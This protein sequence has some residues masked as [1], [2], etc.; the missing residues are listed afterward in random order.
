MRYKAFI[1]YSHTDKDVAAKLEGAL[2]GF[3]KAWYQP[4][5]RRIFRDDS[6]IQLGPL[7]EG[8]AG[9]LQESEFFLLLASPAAAKS[10]WVAREVD[11]WLQR[12]G[13]TNLLIVLT[14]G[15]LA[16]N[17]ARSTH[18]PER[19]TAL[20]SPLIDAF[21]R[22]PLYADLSWTGEPGDLTLANPDFKKTIAQL[23]A[24]L[25]DRSTEDMIGAEIEQHNKTRRIRNAAVITLSVLLA[26]AIVF[27]GL[28][29]WQTRV[30][31]RQRNEAER[32]RDRALA[33]Q[34]AAG[35][36][37]ALERRNWSLGGLLALESIR[38]DWTPTGFEAWQGAMEL[39]PP[40]S[41][42]LASPEPVTD[43]HF[44][45]DST[46]LFGKSGNSL[47]R[48]EISTSPAVILRRP[49]H[50]PPSPRHQPTWAFDS[51]GRHLVTTD[52]ER[53]LVWD[54]RT[55]ESS[56]QGMPDKNFFAVAISPDGQWIA[57]LCR[58][59]P[60]LLIWKTGSAGAP[61]IV[62][63][64]DNGEAIMSYAFSP[65]SRWFAAGLRTSI[66]IWEL[67]S[68]E[69]QS[70]Q[71]PPWDRAWGPLAFSPDRRWL[72]NWQGGVWRTADWR[73]VKRINPGTY[74]IPLVF[75]TRKWLAIPVG[76]R[77][78]VLAVG[79]WD[80][81]PALPD[82][83]GDHP[84]FSPDDRWL[85]TQSRRG[86]LIGDLSGKLAPRWI[87][88]TDVTNVAFSP[89][90]RW[91]ATGSSDGTVHIWQTDTLREESKLSLD[92]KVRA[93]AFSPGSK[94]LATGSSTA[95]RLWDV[96]SRSVEIKPRMT[97]A[98][99]GSGNSLSAQRHGNN[100]T[101]VRADG[102]QKLFEVAHA[103]QFGNAVFSPDGQWVAVLLTRGDKTAAGARLWNLQTL[104]ME[105]IPGAPVAF[106]PD[107]RK[108]LTDLQEEDSL[109]LTLLTLDASSPPVTWT[110]HKQR[111]WNSLT[112]PAA[113][114][115]ADGSTLAIGTGT[116]TR[117]RR[118]KPLDGRLRVWHV[119]DL[120][121][122]QE[123]AFEAPVTAVDFSP[124]GARIALII[125]TG[126][127]DNRGDLLIRDLV[128][129]R[130][131]NG[132]EI[133]GQP[134][135]SAN[136]RRLVALGQQSPARL[137]AW[138]LPDGNGPADGLQRSDFGVAG[139]PSAWCLSADGELV[140][141][142]THD[143][144]IR[145]R[146]VANG[147]E[148]WR[149][150]HGGVI[151]EL[152]FSQSGKELKSFSRD[153]HFQVWQTRS[154]L[155]VD[156]S[157]GAKWSKQRLKALER[158]LARQPLESPAWN[159]ITD[160]YRVTDVAFSPDKRW[161]A[162]TGED[163]VVMIWT[164]PGG[165][166]AARLPH[167]QTPQRLRFDNNGRWLAVKSTND[168]CIWSVGLWEL[169]SCKSHA[170]SVA[171][172]VFSPSGSYVATLSH[173]SLRLW[174]PDQPGQIPTLQHS[175]KVRAVAFS[176][177]ERLVATASDT[178]E[179]GVWEIPSGEAILTTTLDDPAA[180]AALSPDNEWLAV[181]ADGDI[182]VLEVT[183]G[184]EVARFVV[185]DF[186]DAGFTSEG[187][188]LVGSTDSE[189]Y[190][191]PWSAA[192][193]VAHTCQ[194]LPRNLSYE[195]WN[196]YMSGQP[197]QKTCPGLPLHPS[198]QAEADQR[199]EQGDFAG[200]V[201][202]LSLIHRLDKGKIDQGGD[203]ERRAAP[204]LLVSG[205]QLARRG[206]IKEALEA[207]TEAREF[208]P[209]IKIAPKAW[210][211]LCWYGSLWGQP[212]LVLRHCEQAV[213]LGD[214]NVRLRDSR[215]LARALT[216]DY[217]G[218][219]D[220]FQSYINN[221]SSLEEQKEKRR[222]WIETLEAGKNPFTPEVLEILRSEQT[223]P[224]SFL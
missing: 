16:W 96:V 21:S 151:T 37:E 8:V 146:E 24:T 129:D 171:G 200:A 125:A 206:R 217:K 214:Q 111:G 139:R 173:G 73:Y 177:D 52:G 90:S 101:V 59:A 178:G 153:G 70:L 30:A 198:L 204:A 45:A 127:S 107:S 160:R 201:Q 190:L 208:D 184:Q 15:S 175:G 65:D 55:L 220:D 164:A 170:K 155:P 219:I 121:L 136:G 14:G 137:Q 46:Q 179:L 202:M 120:H 167:P 176:M 169:Q 135:F 123:V 39:L 126:I 47:L 85:A 130:N 119:E 58:R 104:K 138:I 218:A 172:V 95:I 2:Q 57:A 76:N 213:K 60:G 188:I 223:D 50:W 145:L 154:G 13:T 128:Q 147:K 115:S 63:G 84:V 36:R 72:V 29:T 4:R 17:D 221:D 67:A 33:R 174:R 41:E 77:V 92:P 203:L 210:N 182:R 122:Q 180:A 191:L 44:T 158:A 51:T 109:T 215:G 196:V 27:A 53:V 165:E 144:E 25:E 112:A 134:R 157:D 86:V 224:E 132:G 148:V 197:Y 141:I 81:N 64:I 94:R 20:P 10:A 87:A 38:R 88:Q 207:Y 48:W 69:A 6:N 205:R 97:A 61:R 99:S 34:L 103:P 163:G 7:R 26:L 23:T 93:L 187:K 68:G 193:L 71:Q 159:E 168:V 11:S 56:S 42:K 118:F 133:D 82:L 152:T 74:R 124:D 106:S 216:G 9:A 22:E 102:G 83:Q 185:A 116:R 80:R 19:T 195:E 166:R 156:N 162:T 100:Y 31:R 78:S 209:Q 189:Q 3:G 66:K 110:Q 150:F 35:S 62:A 114:I 186:I 40:S 113:A 199:I 54:T 91:L 181:V 143:G 18:D 12:H 43:L 140:A 183:T 211:T 105:Q 75:S 192:A 117:D 149:A 32:Q 222:A 28:A 79:S 98:A 1:S 5:A 89:D 142:A 212:Q 49:H 161:L 194:R 131:F 108:L